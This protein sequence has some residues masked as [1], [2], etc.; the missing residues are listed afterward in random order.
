MY[1]LS[2]E[3]VEAI[4]NYLAN[5]P[6]REVAGLINSIQQTCAQQE[7]GEVTDES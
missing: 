4:L 2:K 5:Q 3:Q 1:N 7:K 6:F